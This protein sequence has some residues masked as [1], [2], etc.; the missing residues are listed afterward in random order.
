M[1]EDRDRLEPVWLQQTID[2]IPWYHE[3]DFPNG[4]RA[5]SKLPPAEIEFHHKLW[6]WIR[7]E[8]DK[9][10]FAGKTVLDIGCWDGY[11]SFYA[12]QRAASR[13]LAT[14]DKSQNWAGNAGLELAKQL[15][16]S[17]IETRT[18]VSIYELAKVKERFDIVLCMGVYYH[19]VDPFFAFSQVRHC[20]H[21]RSIV[22]FEGDFAADGVVRPSQAAFFDLADERRCFLP[23]L[24]CL[25]QLLAANYFR[26]LRGSHIHG[27]VLVVCEPF[28]GE[29]GLHRYR[30]PFG[31]HQYDSRFSDH[32][33]ASLLRHNARVALRGGGNLVA[34]RLN[35]V[36]ALRLE[37]FHLSAYKG[38]FKI[39]SRFWL[40]V[41]RPRSAVHVRASLLRHNARVALRNGNRAAARAN[42]VEALR[43][44][45][46]HLKAYKGLIETFLP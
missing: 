2:Q 30:P 37:P 22:V 11:W 32:A 16:G 26:V 8:L 24:T 13:I 27:R 3:F 4:F 1:Q 23:T 18:D 39:L 36:E 14:D 29:N 34:A 6:A 44:E 20:T 15:L 9:I 7:S 40:H 19:L 21:E 43:L 38:L 17:S 10:D 45:P 5:R 31:L 46:S 35:F 42:F 25:L 12:E 28:V 33:R 41:R